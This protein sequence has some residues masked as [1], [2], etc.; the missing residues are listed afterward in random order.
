MT[1]GTNRERAGFSAATLATTLE[2]PVLLVRRPVFERQAVQH[3]GHLA[4]TTQTF[5][6]AMLSSYP[7]SSHALNSGPAGPTNAD[8]IW[9]AVSVP[10][11][12]NSRI[13][14]PRIEQKH[15]MLHRTI[16][17]TVFMETTR[18][19]VRGRFGVR[20]I[21]SHKGVSALPYGLDCCLVGAIIV[22]WL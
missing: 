13:L 11:L 6:A 7:A 19:L 20:V 4:S 8:G 15:L 21:S 9:I 10:L 17:E 18:R 22:P 14:N 16:A 1:C 3:G 2:Q 12:P 5:W